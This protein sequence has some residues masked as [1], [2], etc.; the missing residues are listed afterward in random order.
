MRKGTILINPWVSETHQ[1]RRS[2]YMGIK[3]KYFETWY[4]YD[5]KL[6]KVQ[7]YKSDLKDFIKDGFSTVLSNFVKDLEFDLG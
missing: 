4:V 1:F 3:G 5:G 7:F 2:I 6:E